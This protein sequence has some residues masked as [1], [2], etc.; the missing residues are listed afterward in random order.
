[1]CSMNRRRHSLAIA[2]AIAFGTCSAQS[3]GVAALKEQTFHDDSSARAVAYTQ[4]IDSHGPYLRIVS[5]GTNIEILRSKLVGRVE[6]PDRT[7]ASIMDEKDLAPVRETLAAVRQFTA[8]YPKSTPLL[9]KQTAALA[10][11][12]SHFAGGEI[13]FE[14]TWMSKKQLSAIMDTRRRENEASQAVEVEKRVYE[15]SQRDK[16]MVLHDGKWMTKQAVEEFP[17]EST[18]EI[19]EAMEPLWNGDLQAAR[20][21]VKNLTDLTSRQTGA[22]KVRSERLMLAVRNL[23]AAEARLTQ[24][25]I[26]RTSD[27][28][29][30]AKHDQNAQQWLIPNGFGTVNEN[31]ARE[32]REKARKIRQ[33]SADQFA[34]SRQDLIDQLR[35]TDVVIG[36][37]HK[38]QEHRVVLILAEAVR[39]VSTRHFKPAEF[40]SSFPEE[41]LASIRGQ[42]LRDRD[43]APTP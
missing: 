6:L 14:G 38:L 13:R 43:S 5:G 17:P 36:D 26:A 10:A 37:F 25:T 21:A 27:N 8:R 31:V 19:S 7:P 33:H 24:Q 35:E 12:V 28:L 3:A 16:G 18:T 9:E 41:S 32:S 4:I 40:R 1:M 39:A 30:A 2:C 23:F 29:E 15:A 42:I 22:P 11:H 20:F 34:R